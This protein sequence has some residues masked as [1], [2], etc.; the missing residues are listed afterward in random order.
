MSIPALGTFLTA[1]TVVAADSP[2]FY[3]LELALDGSRRIE[4]RI[5]RDG[6]SWAR[7]KD[8]YLDRYHNA[9]CVGAFYHRRR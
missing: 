3:L 4:V 5:V 1:D 6:P 8:V 2:A 7:D 9:G